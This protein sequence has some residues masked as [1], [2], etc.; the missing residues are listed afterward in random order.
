LTF[1]PA[2]TRQTIT[3][4]VLGDLL[5]E[6]DETFFVN[7]S[8]LSGATFEDSQGRGTITDDDPPPALTIDDVTVAEGNAGTVEA[9]FTVSLSAASGLPVTVDYSTADGSAT[10]ADVDYLSTAG[11]LNFPPGTISQTLNVT[12]NGDTVVEENETVLVNLS[13]ATSATMGD[14]QGTGTILN[15]DELTISIGDV[16][17]TEGNGGAVDAVFVVALSAASDQPVTVEYATTDDTATAGLDYVAISPA[18]LT[19]GIGM[20]T[21]PITITI[22]SDLLDELDE[23]FFVNLSNPSSGTIFDGQG[24]GTITDDDDPPALSIDD[25]TVTEGDSGTTDA[26][27]TV[28]LDAASSLTVT[29]DVASADNSALAPTDYLTATGTLTFTPG[30]TTQPFT[31][32]VQGDTLDE[33]DETFVVN[34]SGAMN[35]SIGDGQGLGSITDDDGLCNAPDLTLTAVA[36]T[37][38]R[39][40]QPDSNFG[41]DPD[42]RTRPVTSNSRSTLI[43]FD[44]AAIPPNS[45]VTCAALLLH[46]NS[47]PDPA[48]YA[49]IHRLTNS[50]TEGQ[51]TWITRTLG[52]NWTTPGGDYEATIEATFV[53]STTNHAVNVAP[54]TQ[55]WIDNPSSNFGLL[56]A[57][58]NN[59]SN[60]E[61]QYASRNVITPTLRPRLEIEYIP[62]LSINDVTVTEGE[63]GSQAAVFTVTL[64]S[65]SSEIVT[66]DFATADNTATISNNDYEFASGTLTFTTGITT[67]P[68]TVQIAGDTNN[69]PVESFF[70]NLSNPVNAAILDGQGEG[71]IQPDISGLSLPAQPHSIFLP[72][73]LK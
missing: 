24:L 34:L 6:N 3:V 32:S 60:G 9:V 72:L 57:A 37:Y 41:S 5:D 68:V 36:D 10:A 61:I 43:Q 14:N 1:P 53:P 47:A 29:V 65:A 26:V 25:V 11:S 21:R 49:H 42:L 40:N 46:Q 52:I 23:T 45:V 15:D 12:I 64:S 33:L 7:L 39:R 27:F 22:Y 62:T 2:S 51:A 55:F 67:Q 44:L 38:L 71:I 48:Q 54:L 20:I 17:V 31:V 50:W 18:T 69:E 59:G 8:N 28:S 58:E 70:V 13:N 63:S 35:A 66:V 4:E 56:L 16:T 73:I 30:F 19:F